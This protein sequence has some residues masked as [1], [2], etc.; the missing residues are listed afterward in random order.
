MLE[1][2]LRTDG[3]GPETAVSSTLEWRVRASLPVEYVVVECRA[4]FETSNTALLLPDHDAP[5]GSLRRLL[6]VDREVYRLYGAA[7][8]N[9]FRHHCSAHRVVLLD[10]HERLKNLDQVNT[11]LAAIAEFGLDRRS[12]PLIAIGGGIILDIVGLA[13]SIYRRRI[14]YIRV[15]TTLLALVD[16][17][18]GVKTGVNFCGHKNRIGTYFAPLAALLDRSFL[19]TLPM[20]H[21]RNGM[22]EI[23]KMALVK[24]RSLFS[25]L[26]NHGQ[27]LLA[28]N[29]TRS[30][31][32]T[33]VLRLSVE[34]MLEELEPNLWEDNLE[35][36]VDFG[37]SFSPVLEMAA[38]ELLH[39]EA[40]A[41]DMC[42]SIAIARNRALLSEDDF[43]RCLAV[44]HA[45]GL[46]AAHPAC[47]PNNLAK[48]LRE[49]AQH[50]GGKQRIPVPYGIGR[51][52]F[53][54]D[55]SVAEVLAACAL[56]QPE[57]SS[58][59]IGSMLGGA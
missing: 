12:E 45:L 34:R 27:A 3:G 33:T 28:E 23:L 21:T 20:R 1:A 32:A 14:P 8:E 52:V 13:A 59:A 2:I 49:I 53:L 16:A 26:E 10:S 22:A 41:V 19:S 9:Y 50:R 40:V 5:R 24:D 17:A 57:H 11:V 39:G 46:P 54:D 25:L 30:H 4:L 6:C 43:R 44:V 42:I 15:P 56:L 47:T 35:R 18:V 37:H 55:I 36:L 31:A 29:F 48:A 58:T 38:P 51:A 7:I